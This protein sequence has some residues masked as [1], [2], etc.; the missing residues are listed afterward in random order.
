[1]HN[2]KSLPFINNIMVTKVIEEDNI[3]GRLILLN[4]ILKKRFNGKNIIID[5]FK[6]EKER[7]KKIHTYFDIE[8]KQDNIKYI[9]NSKIYLNN[10]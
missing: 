1:M 5:K 6:S 4:D 8:I 3:L 10:K 7:I 9:E 2:N